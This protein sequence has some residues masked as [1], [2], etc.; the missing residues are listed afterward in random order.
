[1]WEYKVGINVIIS[2]FVC[3]WKSRISTNAPYGGEADLN[4]N[5][6]LIVFFQT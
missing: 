6:T 1:M 5:S 4:L 2:N 3:M